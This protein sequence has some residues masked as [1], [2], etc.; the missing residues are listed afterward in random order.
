MYWDVDR[1]QLCHGVD[2]CG[3]I[4]AGLPCENQVEE[5]IALLSLFWIRMA[6]RKGIVMGL[7]LR[8]LPISGLPR[9][10]KN[11]PN[12]WLPNT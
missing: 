6:M 8:L 4:I 10:D 11:F 2:Y 12:T 3:I 1:G 5:E 7:N 9:D